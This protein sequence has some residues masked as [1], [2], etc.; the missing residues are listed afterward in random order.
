MTAAAAGPCRASNAC[1]ASSST[2]QAGSRAAR[3]WARSASRQP[4]L[5]TTARPPFDFADDQVVEHAALLVGEQR[6]AQAA[7]GEPDEV[8]RHQL[9]ERRGG[10]AAADQHLAHVRDVEQRRG[11]AAVPVLGHDPGR[12]V[13]RQAPAGELDHPARELEVQLVQRRAPRRGRGSAGRAA[14]E[15]EELKARVSAGSLPDARASTV[16]PPLSLT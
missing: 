4:A 12:V 14:D 15:D 5:T 1:S 8:G 6:V 3:R 11:R 9:L 7:F 10:P 13:H 2:A 16:Q